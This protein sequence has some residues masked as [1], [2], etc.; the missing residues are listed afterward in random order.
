MTGQDIDGKLI[1]EEVRNEIKEEIQGMNRKPCLAIIQVGSN[2]ESNKSVNIKKIL[3]KE[4]GIETLEYLFPEQ[5]SQETVLATISEL[6]LN[7]SI[8]GICF[9]RPPP[10]HINADLALQQILPKKDV[11]G[12]HPLNIANIINTRI[13][14]ENSN[15]LDWILNDG[16]NHLACLPMACL[17]LLRRIGVNLDGED[18][19]IIGR[20]NR[21][22]LPL[23]LLLTHCN[24][25]VTT[26]H[27][28][29]RRIHEIIKRS[30]IVITS[31]GKPNTI[32]AS[33]LKP[34]AIVIDLGTTPTITDK[35]LVLLGDCD[36]EECKEVVSYITPPGQAGGLGSLSFAMMLKNI[37]IA[38]KTSSDFDFI[39]LTSQKII[40]PKR[41]TIRI[42]NNNVTKS[43]PPP[44]PL[45]PSINFPRPPPPPPTMGFPMPPPPPTPAFFPPPPPPFPSV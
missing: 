30:T 3:C 35:G 32:K 41:T 28:S 26:V 1:A 8:D 24:A 38:S 40:N 18:V 7:P 44:P 13:I 10:S 27:S 19:V 12:L 25:T 23:S 5:T 43:Q 21:V 31:I 39:Q 33:W 29:T 45:P 16:N 4:V 42:D 2:A 34:G 11:E 14:S 6:N 36:Y 15:S 37:L 22:S 20:S 9:Q 17:E